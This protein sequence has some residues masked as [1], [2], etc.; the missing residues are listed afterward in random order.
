MGLSSHKSRGFG[1]VER[2]AVTAGRIHVE[3]YKGEVKPPP[4]KRRLLQTDGEPKSPALRVGDGMLVLQ[5]KLA[6]LGVA[7]VITTHILRY[8][9]L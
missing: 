3:R 6:P 9:S 8:P 1:A 4:L 5:P 7:I 2:L